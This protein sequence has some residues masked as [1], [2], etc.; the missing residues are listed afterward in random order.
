MIED[1]A[2]RVTNGPLIVMGLIIAL[3]TTAMLAA[4]FV[5]SLVA[6]SIPGNEALAITTLRGLGTAQGTFSRSDWYGIGKRSYARSPL[7]LYTHD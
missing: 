1:Q 4:V 7:H 2:S 6:P 3:G 5:P